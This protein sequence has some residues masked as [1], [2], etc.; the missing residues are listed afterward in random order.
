MIIRKHRAAPRSGAAVVETALVMMMFC[1]FLFGTIEFGRLLFT[2][3]IASN[4]ATY[5]C[6]YAVARTGDGTTKAQIIDKCDALLV[7]V[8]TAIPGYDKN[9]N[10]DV[11]ATQLGV[12]P[13]VADPSLEWNDAPFG[14]GIAVRVFGPYP[15]MASGLLD[16]FGTGAL[17]NFQINVNAVFNCEAN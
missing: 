5:A 10:I 11:F 9:S 8:K 17:D 4:A 3:H 15:I 16:P 1:M 12:S 13:P 6:R 2:L 14:T 7:G